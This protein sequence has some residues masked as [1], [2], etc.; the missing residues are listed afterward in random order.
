MIRRASRDLQ[1][2][3]PRCIHGVASEGFAADAS[4]YDRVRPSYPALGVA[5]ALGD[6]DAAWARILDVASGTGILTRRLLEF[7]A[8]DVAAV[9]PVAAMRAEFERAVAGVPISD[10]TADALPFGDGAFDVACVGQAFHWFANEQS[11]VEL[12]RVLADGGRLALLWNLEDDSEPWVR[13][14]REAYEVH[15]TGAQGD[16]PQYRKGRWRAAFET[17][18]AR[19]AFPGGCESAFFDNFLLTTR[20]GS[21]ARSKSYCATLPPDQRNALVAEIAAIV[22]HYEASGASPSTSRRR[23]R[24]GAAAD[25]PRS[26]SPSAARVPGNRRR[27]PAGAARG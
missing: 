5:H 22:D 11:L 20:A 13:A 14:V 2:M 24:A 27:A 12:G 26:P 23:R 19:A 8:R 4:L 3:S 16:V 15:D 10:G 18:G 21:G 6:V 9:E 25:Q 1:R 7:G 17:P